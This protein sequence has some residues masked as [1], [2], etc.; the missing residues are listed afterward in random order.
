MRDIY[1]NPYSRICPGSFL[2][3][4]SE[5][6]YL[7]EPVALLV[8]DITSRL[9]VAIPKAFRRNLPKDEPDFNDKVEALLASEGENLKR[10]HPALVFALGH[11]VPDFSVDSTHLLIE[12][13]FIRQKTTPSKVSEG[14]AADLVKYPTS[15]HKLFVV[16]DP[17]RAIADD[18]AFG[19]AF[20]ERNCT[21]FVVR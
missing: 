15:I 6:D 18:K 12:S 5:R 17:Q 1:D 7:K 13:K 10:E 8:R 19:A 20:S 2:E 3:I 14:I 11:A 16:Y 21:I 9:A 4:V